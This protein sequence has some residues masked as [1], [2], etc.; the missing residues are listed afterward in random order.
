VSL[1]AAAILIALFIV[2]AS[3]KAAKPDVTSSFLLGK[4]APAVISTTLEGKPF[5][6]SRRKGSWVVLN[7]FQSSC[8]PCKA[9][10]PELLAFAAQ[11]AGI[12]DG[13][14]LYTVVKDDSDQAVSNWFAEQGG[15]WPIIKD[16]DGSISTAFGVAQVP[17]TWIIDPSG[18]VVRRYASMITAN[19]LSIDLQQLRQ[20]YG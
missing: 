11:Q 5:D 16:D 19:S 6:L 8:L 15:S 3:G 2:L 12:A 18:T 1:A 7:F 4:P 14:E 10:H 20:A 9:E 17:E 13:A